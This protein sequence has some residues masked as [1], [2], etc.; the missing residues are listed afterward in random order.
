MTTRMQVVIFFPPR[1]I[2]LPECDSGLQVLIALY[3][4]FKKKKAGTRGG[5]VRHAVCHVDY[6]TQLNPV[7]TFIRGIGMAAAVALANKCAFHNNAPPPH[8]CRAAAGGG[9]GPRGGRPDGW[10]ARETDKL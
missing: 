9:G 6:A 1:V 10:R 7:W 8:D 3:D 4:P 2:L 5:G